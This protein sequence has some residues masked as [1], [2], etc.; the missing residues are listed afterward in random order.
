MASASS[1]TAVAPR[2]NRLFVAA[3]DFGTTYSGYAFSSKDDF[4]KEPMKINSNVWNAG[5]RNLLSTKSP[6][7]LLLNPDETFNSF[8]YEAETTY[9]EIVEDDDNYREYYYFHRFKMML[10]NNKVLRRD[11]KILDETDKPLEA[12]KVFS[13]SIKFLKDHLF[14]SIKDKVPEI[15]SDDIHYVL[16]VPAI[17][18]DNAKQ[19]MRE[20]AMKA[21]IKREHLSI[22]LEPEA[23]SIHCQNLPVEKQTVGEVSFLKVVKS[24]TKY[25]IVDLGGGT[26]DITVHQRSGD[27][28]LKE[29]RPASGGP[30]GGKSVDDTFLQ[31]L[32]DLVGKDVIKTLKEENMDDYLELMRE[33]ETKKR[34]VTVAKQGKISMTFPVTISDLVKKSPRG[35]M[36][37]AISASKFKGHVNWKTQKLQIS[38]DLFR[39]FFRKTIDGVICHIQDVLS[40]RNTQDVEN[41]LM[42]GGF[43]ECELV[44][45][46]VHEHFGEKRIIVPDEAGLSVLKGAVLFG[47]IPRAIAMRVSRCTYGIQSWPE[48]DPTKHPQSKKVVINGVPRCKDVFFKYI[49]VG[50]QVRPGYEQTQ[51][52]QALKPDEDTLECTVYASNEEDPKFVTDQTC[53]RLGTLTVPLPRMRAEEPLEIEETMV[54][55]DTE[56]HVVAKDL[57]HNRVFEAFFN[58]LDNN[59]DS[60]A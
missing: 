47:H 35:S 40:D 31:F 49:T 45:N 15:Q 56:L 42:V 39:S 13:M 26:A 55:G 59:A 29:I 10:H 41:I 12:M 11:S 8:G 24:G 53:R 28:R 48:F 32:Y 1:G 25:M 52:F 20:A 30:W 3:I 5:A 19:F 37:A 16:T 7:A 34:S 9:S 2:G 51:I 58:F 6:T 36:E 50:E 27:G 46:A 4:E 17:W 44:Q 23:A 14:K 57:T 33:F 38:T 60:D 54:F 18:D 22:A 21:G 43:S